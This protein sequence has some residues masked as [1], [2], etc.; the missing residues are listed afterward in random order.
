MD[1]P[2]WYIV[3]FVEENSVEAVPCNWFKDFSN[4][5]WPP[6]N[7]IKTAEAIKCRESPSKSWKLYKFKILSKKKITDYFVAMNKANYTQNE[8]DISSGA[9]NIM[10]KNTAFLPLKRIRKPNFKFCE[11]D[12]SY[13][14]AEEC[15]S[16]KI[17]VPS[18]PTFSQTGN[19]MCIIFIS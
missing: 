13:D 5:F 7:K 17:K 12:T 10:S 2:G 6:Y 3:K 15:K 14:S 19:F 1:V 8:S 11:E 16:K 18:F 4:C 9:E